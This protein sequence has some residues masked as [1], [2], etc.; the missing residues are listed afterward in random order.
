[1]VKK[2]I[3]INDVNSSSGEKMDVL[4]NITKVNTMADE[5]LCFVSHQNISSHSSDYYDL[6]KET[7]I[8]GGEMS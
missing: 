5:F 2:K 6:F 8:L 7:R 3:Y 1:M 4:E